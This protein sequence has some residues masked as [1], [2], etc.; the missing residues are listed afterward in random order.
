MQ[1][2][3][4][5]DRPAPRRHRGARIVARPAGPRLKPKACRLSFLSSL[6]V[7]RTVELQ[8]LGQLS[9]ILSAGNL[10]RTELPQMRRDPL[11]V[12]QA[13]PAFEQPID[14]DAERH[15][16]RVPYAMEHRL[17]EERAAQTYAVEPAYQPVFVPHLDRMRVAGVM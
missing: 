16:R 15:L 2:G 13:K 3:L 5:L 11:Q 8:T 10:D 14:Q 6:P 1:R 4:C 17:P 12:Q 9:E 7:E